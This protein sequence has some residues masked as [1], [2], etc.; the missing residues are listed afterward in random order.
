MRA[1]VLERPANVETSPLTIQDVTLP[2]PRPGEVRLQVRCCGVCHTDLHIV[3]G[4]LALPKRPVVPGH[5][6]VGI[7]DAVG[8]DVRVIKEG[9]RVGIP[10]LYSAHVVLQLA[11]HEGC[12]AYVFTRSQAHRDLA[13]KLGAVWVGA[14]EDAPPEPLHA[15]IIFAPA[16]S[17]IPHALSV[18][19]KGGILVLAGVTMSPIPQMNYSLL[20]QER[21]VRTVANSTRQDVRE[22]L[23]LAAE[24]P[25]RTEVQVFDLEEANSALQALKKSEIKVAAVLQIS[26]S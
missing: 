3:E 26:R 20:Y 25:V 18:L 9:D 13:K 6:I 2:I 16:G 7:V 14:A 24:V 10:W 12:E 19:R 1:M 23:E 21:Q 4:D 5:Q 22:F 8:R 11:R 15:S 17:L